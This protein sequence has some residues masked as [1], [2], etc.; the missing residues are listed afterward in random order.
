MKGGLPVENRICDNCMNRIPQNAEDCPKCG[1]HF[2]N[3]NPGGALPV[4]WVLNERYTVNRYMDIDG[5]G[6]FYSGIDSVTMQRVNI[7]EF[8]PVTLCSS[9]D[10]KGMIRSKPGCEVLFKTTRV[11]FLDLYENLL[12][13]GRV[14]GL[15]QV[16]DA[17]E[18]NNTAYAIT[19]K[20]EGT[21][22]A[23]YLTKKS[24]PVEAARALTLMR[25]VMGAVD[26]LHSANLIHRG[27]S[28]ENIILGSG[29]TVYLGGYGTLALRQQGSELKSKLYA[30]YS[31]PEQY[32]ASEFEGR[33]TDT[34]A[35]GAVLYHLCTGTA[36][37]SANERR[38]KDNL[39]PARAVYKDV[40]TF[41]STGIARAM[42]ILPAERL[43]TVP[44]LRLSLTGEGPRNAKEGPFGLSRQQMIIGIAAVSAI[45]VLL[46]IVLMIS[47][48]TRNDNGDSSLQ[49]SS[50]S[51][52]VVSEVEEILVPD[53]VNLDVDDIIGNAAYGEFTFAIPTEEYNSDVKEGI[54]ISQTPPGGSV[55]DGVSEIELL[56]SKGAEPVPMPNL[57]EAGI[58]ET[59]AR[60]QLAELGIDNP[61]VKAEVNSGTYEKGQVV[62]TEPA[63][64]EL[65]T[66]GVD[67]VTIYVAGDVSMVN[68]TNLVGQTQANSE[69][70]LVRLGLQYQVMEVDNSLGAQYN[71]IVEG[72]DPAAGSA[73]PP[74]TTVVTLRVYKKYLMPDLSSYVNGSSA[75]LT[76]FLASK[77]IP[78]TVTEVQNTT[79]QPK[80]NVASLGYT[81]GVEV[82]AS[83][84]VSINVYGDAVAPPVSSTPSTP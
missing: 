30:G 33:Y 62:R 79:G 48:F 64:G 10:V 54:I 42:R 14:D 67:T 84:P 8:M 13:M 76:A 65:V 24:G 47:A 31:A 81:V 41:L 77:N 75:N 1:I 26:M 37:A 45:V 56:V 55:W 74:G 28:P 19:E 66:P 78:Y 52:S 83:T 58:T 69:A 3:T 82:S 7:K 17:F 61:I 27:I 23:E 71:G 44:E 22:L 16:L 4:G 25:P 51:S 50:L 2:N 49:S 57:T 68:I 29:G 21:T 70:E 60:A 43:Q 32:A 39:K 72:T 36:P 35:L 5:E 34:Y 73:V 59:E 53:L 6:V 38:M 46:L 80:G 18:E 11:D 63:S 15:V 40:P 20:V 12:A 9:R